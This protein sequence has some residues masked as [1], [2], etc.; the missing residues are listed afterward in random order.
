MPDITVLVIGTCDTKADEL[1]FIRSCIEGQGAA[2][3][4][5]D[6]GV[7][8]KPRFAPEITND[9]VAA[10]A[11]TTIEAIATCGDENEAMT[12]MAR[13]ASALTAQLH[14]DGRIQA[15]I[16]LGGSMGTD[17]ALDAA[18]ALPV[19][20]PKF[21][22]STIAF[23]HLMPPD[24]MPPDLM[25]ILWAGGL[26]GLNSVCKASLSQASGAVVGAAKAVVR[27]ALDRPLIGM[28]S[29]GSSCLKYMLTLKP[30]LEARGYEVAVFHCTGMGGQAFER[31]AEQGRFAAV[32][33]LCLAE[34]ENEMHGSVVTAG[35]NRLT[36][37]GARGVP[38]IVAPGATD[39]VDFQTWRPLPPK[40]AD[41][42][43][44]AHNRLLASI[45]MTPDERR[46]FTA[47]VSEKLAGAKGPVTFLLPHGGIEQW[48]R[49]GEGLHD[50]DGLA[51]MVNGFKAN[52]PGNVARVDLDCHIN[53]AG[54]PEAVLAV[55][56][57]WVAEGVVPK[58]IPA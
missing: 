18:S 11:G 53:D 21:V 50:P 38:Q 19:G 57:R 46:D 37:A 6:V 39:M 3:L 28:T 23:S 44:H 14:A 9:E 58:G 1:Q 40:Y 17:L 48:D 56:D 25:M 34:V 4:M 55:F 45:T 12:A 47:V 33:D 52:L 10:A 24:R 43:Y 49:P 13:G 29:L 42:P 20:V 35:P 22:V 2:V 26:Y 27:P 36:A 51:A 32:L 41:R 8:S 31:L 54:F 30:A 16:A 7:L 15:M 5:M